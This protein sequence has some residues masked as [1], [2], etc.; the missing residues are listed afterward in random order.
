MQERTVF[1]TDAAQPTNEL[2]S[3]RLFVRWI[4]S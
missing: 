2:R 1:I 3:E 4:R